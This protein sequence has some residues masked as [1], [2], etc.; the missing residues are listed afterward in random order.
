[1]ASNKVL[2]PDCIENWAFTSIYQL[3]GIKTT[4]I[5]SEMETSYLARVTIICILTTTT[6]VVLF[7]QQYT[8]IHI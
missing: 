6:I 3:G 2:S 7:H 5:L 4:E 8:S 1:M